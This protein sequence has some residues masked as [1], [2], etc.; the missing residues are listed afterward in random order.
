MPNFATFLFY[1]LGIVLPVLVL[2]LIRQR[3]VDGN[4]EADNIFCRWGLHELENEICQLCKHVAVQ[5]FLDFL[6]EPD[7]SEEDEDL[8]RY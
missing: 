1:L 6:N 7:F 2:T 8:V 4:P 3:F 5:N